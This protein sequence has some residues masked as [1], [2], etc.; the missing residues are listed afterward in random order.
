MPSLSELPSDLNRT[1]LAKALSRLGFCLNCKGGKGNHF[2]L[3]W[4]KNQK[5]ITL[6]EIRHK[7]TLYYILREV[8]EY[9][10]ITWQE[11][12]KYL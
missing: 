12:K 9:S 11:I 10:G 7:K 5:C 2:K 3:I 8:E 6:P 4:P 1:K